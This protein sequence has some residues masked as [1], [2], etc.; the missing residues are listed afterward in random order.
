MDCYDSK[1]PEIRHFFNLHESSLGRHV[2]A[3]SRKSLETKKPFEAKICILFSAALT[4]HQSI[5]Q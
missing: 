5:S 3:S 2:N 4:H 1:I